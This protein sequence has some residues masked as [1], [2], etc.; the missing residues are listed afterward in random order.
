MNR[1]AR[2]RVYL[3]LASS[4]LGVVAGLLFVL[5]GVFGLPAVEGV[6]APVVA[7]GVLGAAF[8]AVGVGHLYLRADVRGMG[9]FVAGVGAMLVG[10]SFGVTQTTPVFVIGVGGLVV[11]GLVILADSFGVGP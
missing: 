9:E 3:D 10:L 2:Y 5:S 1:T 4:V 7:M 11:G 6:A 8:S